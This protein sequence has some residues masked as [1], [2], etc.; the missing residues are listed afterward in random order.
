[1]SDLAPGN[2]EARVRVGKE[3]DL[4]DR[5]AAHFNHMADRIQSMVEA[6]RTVL[7]RVSHDLRTPVSRIRF[8]LEMLEPSCTAGGEGAGWS[9]QVVLLRALPGTRH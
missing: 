3:D 7:E 6:Q 5:L 2:L 8:N 9:T 4:L 1:M